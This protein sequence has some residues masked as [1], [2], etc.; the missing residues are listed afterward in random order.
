[1]INWRSVS[2]PQVTHYT[3]KF[4]ISDE[5]SPFDVEN[6]NLINA[7]AGMHDAIPRC[8]KIDISDKSYFF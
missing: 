5:F 4:N 2:I 3:L 6:I 1:M 7:F 8:F